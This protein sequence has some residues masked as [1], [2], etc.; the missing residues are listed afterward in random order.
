MGYQFLV[1]DCQQLNTKQKHTA[2][3]LH[4]Y[5]GSFSII[6]SKSTSLSVCDYTITIISS[7]WPSFETLH[8]ENI[9][10]SDGPATSITETIINATKVT[11]QLIYHCSDT[12]K[13]TDN[14]HKT[15]CIGVPIL[16]KSLYCSGAVSVSIAKKNGI[17]RIHKNLSLPCNLPVHK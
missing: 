1:N 6:A 10:L 7:V 3:S 11:I 15:N 5:H 14:T 12:T 8:F 9:F 16:K 17:R 13:I 4:L 2:F